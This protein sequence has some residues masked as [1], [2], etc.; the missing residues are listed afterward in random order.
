L[1]NL[2]SSQFSPK[3]TTWHVAIV[4][5]CIA[6]EAKAAKGTALFNAAPADTRV[7]ADNILRRYRT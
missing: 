1:L 5:A 3:A 2:N 7:G 4:E 6:A